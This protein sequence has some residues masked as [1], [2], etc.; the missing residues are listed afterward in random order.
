MKT[1][2]GL[3]KMIK[4]IG[5]A[6]AVVVV[7]PVLSLEASAGAIKDGFYSGKFSGGS[8]A[9][10]YIKR[11]LQKTVYGQEEVIYGLMLTKA[12]GGSGALYRVEELEDGTQAWIEL[13]QTSD[14]VLSTGDTMEAA[15]IA[16]TEDGGRKIRLSPTAYGQK[17]GCNK[18]FSGKRSSKQVWAA[19]PASGID[20]DH[21]DAVISSKSLTGSF[22]IDG[23]RYNGPFSLTK[24]IDGAYLIRAQVYDAEASDGRELKKE[25]SALVVSVYVE[26][27]FIFDGWKD[28]KY[29]LHFIR[30]QP[31]TATC[32]FA[33]HK[34]SQE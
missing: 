27:K 18:E 14:N 8:R 25:I 2:N 22:T 3:N 5:I 17:L 24:L 19:I 7:I 30:L 1:V 10:V 33:D 31:G 15:Y 21:S 13:V 6:I 4:R 11:V 16:S 29:E 28:D 26:K 32:L 34:Y 20:V 23:V 12:H 9:G